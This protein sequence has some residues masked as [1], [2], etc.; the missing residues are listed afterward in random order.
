MLSG[1]VCWIRYVRGAVAM[2]RM[3]DGARDLWMEFAER[4]GVP[5][6]ALLG[7]LANRLPKE[8]RTPKWLA[9]AVEEARD[10]GVEGRRRR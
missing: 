5:L 10:T 6:S 2:V 7:A 3:D 1:V 4:E 9:D 8:G